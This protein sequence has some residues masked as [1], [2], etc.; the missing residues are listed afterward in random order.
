VEELRDLAY[1]LGRKARSYALEREVWGAVKDIEEHSY[2]GLEKAL[3]A[4]LEGAVGYRPA[5][6]WHQPCG[7][8]D[9]HGSLV[10][11]FELPHTM[12]VHICYSVSY[13]GTGELVLRPSMAYIFVV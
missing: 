3:T 4:R 11:Y 9:G 7:Y 2:E 8:I 12:F 10:F 1:A 5:K 6:R 13:T